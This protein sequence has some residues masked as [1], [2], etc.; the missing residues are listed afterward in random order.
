MFTVNH[1]KG[2][3]YLKKAGTNEFII[4]RRKKKFFEPGSAYNNAKKEKLPKEYLT[5]EYGNLSLSEEFIKHFQITQLVD[6][7]RL[8]R[9]ISILLT[10]FTGPESEDFRKNHTDRLF[11]HLM[12][13]PGLFAEDDL[14][15]ALFSFGEVLQI[16]KTNKITKEDYNTAAK[17]IGS[18]FALLNYDQMLLMS[19][20]G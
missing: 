14:A 20:D 2:K 15:G 12:M 1:D 3:E 16:P 11:F 10:N 8:L 6:M 19:Y 5:Q 9:A 4:K 7:A 13:K 17:I 18:Y